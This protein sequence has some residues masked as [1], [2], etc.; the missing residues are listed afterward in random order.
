M[1][2][3]ILSICAI[4]A[5]LFLSFKPAERRLT[6]EYE[7]AEI[8]EADELLGGSKVLLGENLSEVS[9]VFYPTTLQ[10]GKYSVYATRKA[11]NLYQIDGKNI[12]IQTRLCHEYASSDQLTLVIEV[13]SGYSKGKLIF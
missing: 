6:S 13:G 11:T 3:R 9:E 5:M 2:T 8:Y 12:F 4:I 10:T 7:I 1:K